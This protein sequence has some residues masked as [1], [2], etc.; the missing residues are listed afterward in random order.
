M[1]NI[2]DARRLQ[3]RRLHLSLR[4]HVSTNGSAS[5]TTTSPT[6]TIVHYANFLH[7]PV[8]P[9]STPTTGDSITFFEIV[10]LMCVPVV[11]RR[12]DRVGRRSRSASADCFDATNVITAEIAS[13]ITN[14]NFG[15]HEAA[16]QHARDR[17]P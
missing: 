5:T 9:L 11:P 14:I 7:D 2:L 8:G 6:T 16:R 4:R 1:K 13:C 17:S 12:A 15:P 3:D 10:T